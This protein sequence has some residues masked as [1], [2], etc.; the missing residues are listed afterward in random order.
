LRTG[1]PFERNGGVA[2]WL[3]KAPYSTRIEER[4]GRGSDIE[5]RCETAFRRELEDPRALGVIPQFRE[6]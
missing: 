3:G 1:E 5:D 4:S 2:L 6:T